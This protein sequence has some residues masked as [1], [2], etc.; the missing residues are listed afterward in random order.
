MS[1]PFVLFYYI[2]VS[3]LVM[4]GILFIIFVGDRLVHVMRSVW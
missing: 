2:I 4:E 1:Y 3:S